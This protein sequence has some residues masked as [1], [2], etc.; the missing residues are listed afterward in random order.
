MPPLSRG[1][2]LIVF[3]FRHTFR[4]ESFGR[5]LLV[6]RFDIGNLVS[7]IR[8]RITRIAG[9]G[10]AAL[11]VVVGARGNRLAVQLNFRAATIIVTGPSVSFNPGHF[12]GPLVNIHLVTEAEGSSV[13]EN[14][15]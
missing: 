1:E 6:F 3:G 2:H 7:R 13:L 11:D 9:E 12:I 4:N 15:S 14:L 10:S 5:K 8:G